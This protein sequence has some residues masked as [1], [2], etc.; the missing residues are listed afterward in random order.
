MAR[1]G[2][3]AAETGE[4]SELYDTLSQ[5]GQDKWDEI[6]LLGFTPE[7]GAAGLWFARKPGQKA[8]EAVGPADSLD[9]LFSQ[10][11]AT[12]PEEEADT[13]FDEQDI[14]DMA[15]DLEDGEGNPCLPGTAPKVIKALA[16][17]IRNYDEIKLQRVELSNR[18][19]TAKKD[20]A[21]Q[22]KRYEKH[23]E[24]DVEK[25]EKYYVVGKIRGKI[26]IEEKEVFQTDHVAPEDE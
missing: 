13:I 14:E 18:E 7:K 23:L 16:F 10:L 4:P 17:A 6:A 15:E 20:L 21:F 3:A 1:N 22:L 11:K 24:T 2:M 12:L 26:K 8:K 19:A 9:S 25:K 5:A